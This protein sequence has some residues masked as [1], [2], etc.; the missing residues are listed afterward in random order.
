[1]FICGATMHL[2]VEQEASVI[3]CRASPLLLRVPAATHISIVNSIPGS[4]RILFRI[5]ADV[6]AWVSSPQF[7]CFTKCCTSTKVQILTRRGRCSYTQLL[8]VPAVQN[9]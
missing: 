8:R 6:I 7:T 2:P 5:L 3:A 4:I 9:I 1:M